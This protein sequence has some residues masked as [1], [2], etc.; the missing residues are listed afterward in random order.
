[1]LTQAVPPQQPYKFFMSQPQTS[2]AQPQAANIMPQQRI[3]MAQPRMP[4]PNMYAPPFNQF[5]QINVPPP[6]MSMP[7]PAV[8]ADP[9]NQ[10]MPVMHHQGFYQN[11]QMLLDYEARRA[12]RK[13]MRRT[14][15]YNA[16]IMQQI[17]VNKL[18]QKKS[19]SVF[20]F[21]HTDSRSFLDSRGIFTWVLDM[22][23]HF[24]RDIKIVKGF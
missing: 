9:T 3:P 19:E 6:N 13:S 22:Q 14:V 2:G 7:P 5:K 1:M 12:Q 11:N 24:S 8:P 15:D 23:G 10:Q 21:T 4:M 16:S 17:K 20:I 18:E